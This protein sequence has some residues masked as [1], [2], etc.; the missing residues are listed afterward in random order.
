MAGDYE[1]I[2][3]DIETRLVSAASEAFAEDLAS[4]ILYGSAAR[5]MYRRGV[6]DVNILILLEKSSPRKI[7]RFGR[8]AARLIRRLKVTPLIMSRIE[9]DSSADV[10]PM[11]YHDIRDSHKILF[12]KNDISVPVPNRTNLRHQMEERLRGAVNDLRQML[13]AAAGRERVLGAFLKGWSGAPNAL[14]RGLVRLKASEAPPADPEELLSRVSREYGIDTLAFSELNLL[15]KGEKRSPL[16]VAE[17]LLEALKA[18][19][20]VVDA[21]PADGGSA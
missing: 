18:F 12:G 5:G 17:A 10:F 8:T 16:L 19:A 11:E 3:H 15:R 4:V 21:M 20:A 2:S 6:S 7:F 9:F 13:S 1:K 14:F